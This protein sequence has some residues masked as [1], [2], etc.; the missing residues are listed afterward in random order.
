MSV[1]EKTES[2]LS[3]Y[4]ELEN[5]SGSTYGLPEGKRISGL[6]NMAQFELTMRRKLTYCRVFRN[7]IIHNSIGRTFDAEPTDEMISFLD[8]VIERIQNPLKCKNIAIPMSSMLWRSID[9]ALMPTMRTMRRENFTHIPILADGRVT[10]VLSESSVF[11]YLADSG[12]TMIEEND[13]ISI[14]QEYLGLEEREAE[15][16]VFLPWD[17]DVS[18]AK[19]AF[20]ERYEKNERLGMILFTQN[21]SKGEKLLGALTA[22]DLTL[23]K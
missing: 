22:W 8:D 10:G 3:K 6:E 18:D 1:V 23:M 13:R 2:F 21:G 15:R 4:R 9:D 7:E 16:F 11:L 17:A 12:A 14:L 20:A 19:E 5:V